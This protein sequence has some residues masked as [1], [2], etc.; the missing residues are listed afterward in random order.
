MRATSSQPG[1]LVGPWP[2]L[3]GPALIDGGVVDQQVLEMIGEVRI[4]DIQLA[5]LR[6]A[7]NRVH[8]SAGVG[9]SRVDRSVDLSRIGKAV[10]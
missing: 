7:G 5:S 9:P 8:F 10:K 1:N 2:T 4:A 6:T 3:N